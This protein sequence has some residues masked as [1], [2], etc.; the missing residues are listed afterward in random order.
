MPSSFTDL[1][2]PIPSDN[3]ITH[4]ASNPYHITN[5]Q[6][7]S[8]YRPYVYHH[9]VI[10]IGH[11]RAFGAEAD[12]KGCAQGRSIQHQ[13]RGP[14]TSHPCFCAMAPHSNAMQC[15]E[16]QSSVPSSS[17]IYSPKAFRAITLLASETGRTDG[18][19]S[20]LSG[21]LNA[22][23]AVC[24]WMARAAHRWEERMQQFSV[25]CMILS[26][27]HNGWSM[28]HTMS[29]FQWRFPLYLEKQLDRWKMHVE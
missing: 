10:K 20:N 18:Q 13:P 5:K 12:I 25:I 7:L 3:N 22:F 19:T 16:T 15:N 23:M 26:Q 27:Q 9:T 8:M 17:A 28:I 14:L 21:E 24:G 4:H 1:C 2:G 29:N 6:E 11:I